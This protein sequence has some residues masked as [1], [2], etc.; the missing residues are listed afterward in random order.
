MILVRNF[1]LLR[2]IETQGI[3]N[4]PYIIRAVRG[5]LWSRQDVRLRRERHLSS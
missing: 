4:V 3:V 1:H 5:F 2:R